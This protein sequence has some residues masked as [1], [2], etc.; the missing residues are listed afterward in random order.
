MSRCIGKKSPLSEI[1]PQQC[2]LENHHNGGCKFEEPRRLC[3]FVQG[4]AWGNRHGALDR[5]ILEVD[6]IIGNQKLYSDIRLRH[7]I[8][9]LVEFNDQGVNDWSKK[10]AS[11]VEIRENADVNNEGTVVA[12]WVGGERQQL[13][14]RDVG[15]RDVHWE[16]IHGKVC[17]D[18]FAHMFKAADFP[19]GT[20]PHWV[21]VQL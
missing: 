8:E 10:V 6:R 3:I 16:T 11:V 14:L 19:N 4:A 13:T 21:E 9:H 15:I 12:R 17:L 20:C 1:N 5:V 2:T 18:C 7:W